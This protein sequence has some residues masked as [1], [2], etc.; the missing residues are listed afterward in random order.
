MHAQSPSPKQAQ[1]LRA[2]MTLVAGACLPLLCVAIVDAWASLCLGALQTELTWRHYGAYLSPVVLLAAALVI[3]VRGMWR[4]A[5][6]SKGAMLGLGGLVVVAA[7]LNQG[8]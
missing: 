8:L 1:R 4:S 5:L 2:L 3:C 6:P 7:L